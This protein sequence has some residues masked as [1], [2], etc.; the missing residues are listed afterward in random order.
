[1]SV[2]CGQQDCLQWGLPAARETQ[3]VEMS[4]PPPQVHRFL[5]NPAKPV[6]LAM[7]RPDAKKNVAALIKAYGSS[8]VLRDLANLVLVLVRRGGCAHGNTRLFSDYNFGG[9]FRDTESCETS[10]R[11]LDGGLSCLLLAHNPPLL[12][13]TISTGQS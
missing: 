9:A 3:H 7:S 11:Q 1:M 5:R 8:A 10:Y 13:L 4:A 6:I 12:A 2:Q